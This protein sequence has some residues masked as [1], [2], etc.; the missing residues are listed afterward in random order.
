MPAPATLSA[1]GT[2]G[3]ALRNTPPAQKL[4]LLQKTPTTERYFVQSPMRGFAQEPP[5][6]A[7]LHKK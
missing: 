1:F 5:S 3:T 6:A 4:T 7:S 2:S